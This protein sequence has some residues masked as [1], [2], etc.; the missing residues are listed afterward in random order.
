[1]TAAAAPSS[2]GRLP[3]GR[4]A[5]GRL[6]NAFYLSIYMAALLYVYV[7]FLNANFPYLGMTLDPQKW[8]HVPFSVVICLAFSQWLR[9]HFRRFSHFFLAMI[10]HFSFVPTMLFVP[11]QTAENIHPAAF[12]LGL[13]AAMAIAAAVSSIRIRLPGYPL[14]ARLFFMLVSGVF[15][16]LAGYILAN[17][18][19]TAFNLAA[20]NDVYEQ[21]SEGSAALGGVLTAYAAG[22][23][24]NSVAPLLLAAGIVRRNWA[25]IG[26]GIAGLLLVYGLLA[27]KSVVLTIIIIP[28]FY[29]VAIRNGPANGTHIAKLALLL[30]APP[31]LLFQALGWDPEPTAKNALVSMIFMRTLGLPAALTGVYADFFAVNP[32]TAYSH[33]NIIKPFVT[34]PYD[35]SLGFVISGQALNVPGMNANASLWATD[36]IAAFGLWGLPLAG[37]F[38]GIVLMIA[39]ALTR[40]ADKR[41]VFLSAVP[42]LMIIMNASM[43][44]SLLTGGGGLLFVLLWLMGGEEK[45]SARP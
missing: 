13:A 28:A 17:T 39:D 38:L 26:M 5:P 6:A 40:K 21:R 32:T 14:P 4:A 12:Q 25:M 31:L 2:A 18:D 37:L 35:T 10:F 34:Y 11:L 41:I 23:L 19:L 29:L 24:A 7:H 45:R 16:V 43:F 36:G 15:L 42:F 30:I 9:G 1:M 8:V 27:L 22:I 33:M 44:T 3:L 20:L